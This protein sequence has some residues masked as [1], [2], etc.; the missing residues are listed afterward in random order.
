MNLT[1]RQYRAVDLT[2]LAIILGIAELICSFGANKWFTAA[3][4]VLSPTVALV[5]IV[6]MRW[7]GFAA[8]HAVIGGAA[9][10]FGAGADIAQYAVYAAG[11][12]GILAALLFLK[13]VGKKKVADNFLLTSLYAVIAYVC[14]QV[15]R[16]LVGLMVGG[17]AGDIVR[18][19]TTDSLSLMFAVLVTLIARKVD[20][21][22]EDQKAY[23]I[24]TEEERREEQRLHDHDDYGNYNR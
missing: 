5:C 1:F 3:P 23:L 15:G 24:R 19:L 16:W 18:Y 9:L 20:G 2:T 6:M 10:C 8:I 13:L 4:F 7:D 21:L 14:V 22:F 17:T 12:C 11:N